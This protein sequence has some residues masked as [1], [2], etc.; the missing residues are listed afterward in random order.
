[1]AENKEVL[2]AK[3]LQTGELLTGSDKKTVNYAIAIQSVEFILLNQE[4]RQSKSTQLD[5]QKIVGSNIEKQQ[6]SD[7]E[8]YKILA[9]QKYIEEKQK[10][11]DLENRKQN[12]TKKTTFITK[13]C[14]WVFKFILNSIMLLFV[15][16]CIF[17][18]I[19]K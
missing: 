18:I 10:L 13:F 7:E 11:A 1:M 3:F 17:K 16:Y 14:K 2:R 12:A 8:R 9:E 4:I 6:I 19:H 15:V 5:K